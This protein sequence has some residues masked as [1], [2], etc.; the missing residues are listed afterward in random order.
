MTT[1]TTQ[2]HQYGYMSYYVVERLQS[3]NDVAINRNMK[4]VL[5]YMLS[6]TEH[7]RPCI[8]SQEHI[9]YYLGLTEQQV[10][11]SIKTLKES[12][13]ITVLAFPSSFKAGHTRNVYK[14]NFT[15]KQ[16]HDFHERE[17]KDSEDYSE[18]SIL[19]MAELMLKQEEA[20]TQQE[21]P[22]EA[23]QTLSN[24][25]NVPNQSNTIAS[26]VKD[27]TELP[28]KPEPIEEIEPMSTP[29][30]NKPVEN[31]PGLQDIPETSNL[32]IPQRY[33]DY[34]NRVYPS[35]YVPHSRHD[36]YEEEP[37]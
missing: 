19:E 8:A 7:S 9:A 23:P 31:I 21:V 24:E 17:E 2:K 3:W 13:L 4:C 11:R 32:V 34:R 18:L 36:H 1:S 16:L 28:T 15:L 26:P 29:E 10:Y 30:Q 33:N 6:F 27:L 25:V 20:K 37:F 5:N 35:S 12:G 22:V 14:M